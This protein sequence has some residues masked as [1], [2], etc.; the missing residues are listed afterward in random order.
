M[1]RLTF[2][3]SPSLNAQLGWRRLVAR[4]C[5]KTRR[6]VALNHQNP[7]SEHQGQGGIIVILIVILILNVHRHGG[8]SQVALPQRAIGARGESG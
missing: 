7:N 8:C 4:Y 3:R 5:E 6:A 2:S 1:D